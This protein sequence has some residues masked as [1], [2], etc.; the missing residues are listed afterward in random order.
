MS[1]AA[2]D[3]DRARAEADKSRALAETRALESRQEKDLTLADKTRLGE[4]LQ[5]LKKEVHI[6]YHENIHRMQNNSMAL[7]KLN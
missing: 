3:A 1:R 7:L 6:Q 2:E 5:L 4:E